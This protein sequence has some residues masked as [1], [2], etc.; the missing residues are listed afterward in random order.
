MALIACKD[1]GG[2]V[3]SDAKAFPKCGA[4]ICAAAVDEAGHTAGDA[5]LR[6][7]R[8]LGDDG[9]S[10]LR[11]LTRIRAVTLQPSGG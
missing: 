11:P 10:G 2:D 3:S 4:P 7:H 9:R 1:C 5:V 8:V 6:H